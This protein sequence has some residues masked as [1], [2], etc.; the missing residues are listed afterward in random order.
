MSRDPHRGML[1]YMEL[2]LARRRRCLTRRRSTSVRTERTD[3]VPPPDARRDAR[4]RAD[5]AGRSRRRRI[6]S[7]ADRSR[8]VGFTRVTLTDH[9]RSEVIAE[10]GGLRRIP[11]RVYPA[12]R[13]GGR[14]ALT[15]IDPGEA[16]DAQRRFLQTFFER[17]LDV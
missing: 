9:H 1:P 15:D 5:R 7:A 11:L 8:P 14:P 13:H 12:A 3:D 17:Y 6:A 4:V 2:A 10:E 16:V